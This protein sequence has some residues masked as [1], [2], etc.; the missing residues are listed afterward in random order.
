MNAQPSA[1]VRYQRR[2]HA[3]G[4]CYLCPRPIAKGSRWLCVRHQ[5]PASKYSLARWRARHP[6]AKQK[7][8][9][10]CLKLGHNARTCKEKGEP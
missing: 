1:Q 6:K 7:Q 5:R 4:L 10:A 2:H 3:A 8:C 9:H